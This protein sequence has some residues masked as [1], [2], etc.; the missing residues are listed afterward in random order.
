MTTF[1]KFIE[2]AAGT[3]VLGGGVSALDVVEVV[4]ARDGFIV[5]DV[6]SRPSQGWAGEVISSRIVVPEHAIV[7]FRFEDEGDQ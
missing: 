5:C 2:G 1:G 6:E 3:L 7:Y 4:E